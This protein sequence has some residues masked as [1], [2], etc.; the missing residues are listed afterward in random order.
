MRSLPSPSL[1]Q[2]EKS[3]TRWGSVEGWVQRN[4]GGVI[5]TKGM[6]ID[7]C[8][9]YNNWDS[10]S[11]IQMTLTFVLLLPSSLAWLETSLAP[12]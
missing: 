9:K 6:A 11:V 12:C 2:R 4:P 10:Q 5:K 8:V 1:T 3:I 7:F